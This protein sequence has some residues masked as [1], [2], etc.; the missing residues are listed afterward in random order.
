M[1]ENDPI[2]DHLRAPD[3]VLAGVTLGHD[4][5]DTVD[6]LSRRLPKGQAAV[7]AFLSEPTGH[8]VLITGGRGEGVGAKGER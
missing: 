8:L 5:E 7:G 3:G 6:R 4:L 2:E 1:S